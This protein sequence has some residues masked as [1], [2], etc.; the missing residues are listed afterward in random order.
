MDV[1]LVFIG[2]NNY[3]PFIDMLVPKAREEFYNQYLG[4]LKDDS[5]KD[6]FA[7]GVT[8]DDVACGVVGIVLETDSEAMIT[9]LFVPRA[10]RR[11]GHG[12]ELVLAAADF[13]AAVADRH[14][15]TALVV[16]NDSIKSHLL[17]FFEYLEFAKQVSSDIASYHINLEKLVNNALIQKSAKM[18]KKHDIK[19]FS[20]LKRAE[21]A[22]IA[23]QGYGELA[24]MLS[25]NLIDKEISTC[26]VSANGV[27]TDFVMIEKENEG[28]LNVAWI[29]AYLAN[30]AMIPLL[31]TKA[32][33]AVVKKCKRDTKVVF[34]CINEASITLVKKLFGDDLEV[35]EE[36]IEFSVDLDEPYFHMEEE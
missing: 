29:Q 22:S 32:L 30:G 19:Y 23:N 12:T 33:M 2:P 13:A 36:Y 18:C 5:D 8:E 20:Q 15:L 34:S 9:S 11:R 14:K 3:E 10:Y 27:I 35:L 31:I 16:K 7:F 26:M 1:E 4:E 24:Y 25:K 17:P 6:F 28:V 21:M